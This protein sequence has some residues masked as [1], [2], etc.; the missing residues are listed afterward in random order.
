MC[1]A[2]RHIRPRIAEFPGLGRHDG[3]KC[4]EEMILQLG[5]SIRLLDDI[6]M[7]HIE[8][9]DAGPEHLSEGNRM[10]CRIG[11][12]FCKVRGEKNP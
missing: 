5:Q 7:N 10:G 4:P 3:I 12:S 11:C 6:V 9:I 2:D 8:Y 1:T